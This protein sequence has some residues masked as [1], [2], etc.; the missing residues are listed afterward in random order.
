VGEDFSRTFAATARGLDFFKPRPSIPIGG[1]VAWSL[2]QFLNMSEI[3]TFTALGVD[4]LR[5][6]ISVVNL[7]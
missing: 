1:A 5:I 6:I 7:H 3:L 4:V 2:S